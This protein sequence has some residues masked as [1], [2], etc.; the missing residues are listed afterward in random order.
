M[1]FFQL[2]GNMQGLYQYLKKGIKL[3]LLII[4]RPISILSNFS[5]VFE[6]IIGDILW[7]YVLLSLSTNQHGFVPQRSTLTN[8]FTFLIKIENYL[9]YNQ[10]VDVIFTDLSE[11]IDCVDHQLIILKLRELASQINY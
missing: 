11:A 10:Q 8:L 5:K 6:M 3:L 9:L 1:A 4:Y 2:R 7:S